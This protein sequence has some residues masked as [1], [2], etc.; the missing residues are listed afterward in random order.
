VVALPVHPNPNVQRPVRKL[1]GGHP[2]IRL[3]S[4]L[5]YVPFLALMRR[6]YLILT[7]SGGVQ[8]E[9]PS[10]GVPVLVLRK[11]TERP[12]AAEAGLA[13]IIGTDPNAIVQH[14]GEL[15]GDEQTYHQMTTAINPYGD[16]LAS[17]RIVE[18]LRNWRC[19]R[20][21]LA[22]DRSFSPELRRTTNPWEPG[23]V[24]LR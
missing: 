3:L 7:D 9:A 2:R 23:T 8:E 6:A 1:L 21:L 5:E 13:R 14:V 4:P 15:L 10:L 18:V 20:P 12:E 19:G 11:I 22:K 16:G 17:E 24:H